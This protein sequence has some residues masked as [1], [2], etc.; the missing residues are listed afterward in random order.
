MIRRPP[1]KATELDDYDATYPPGSYTA[2]RLWRMAAR[3][4]D[5]GAIRSD[6]VEARSV[7]DLWGLDRSQQIQLLDDIRGLDGAYNRGRGDE[8]ERWA[9]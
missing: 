3:Y 7:L 9:D 2:V 8:I 1:E 6:L 4:L 5:G